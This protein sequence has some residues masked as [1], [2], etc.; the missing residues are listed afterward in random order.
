MIRPTITTIIK[1]IYP[2]T[3]DE[4]TNRIFDQYILLELGDG[5]LLKIF[6]DKILIY[7][8]MVNMKMKMTIS[9]FIPQTQKNSEERFS[10]K[11]EYK[12]SNAEKHLPMHFE[13]KIEEFNESRDRFIL[14]IG[15]GSIEVDVHPFQVEGFEPGD[16]V[17][18]DVYRIDLNVLY[19]DN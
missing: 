15:T 10:V 7:P 3:V 6:D 4:E 16:F 5:S 11:S 12:F 17:K 8:E 13:G 14:N 9:A 2:S 1:K 18:F 19:P